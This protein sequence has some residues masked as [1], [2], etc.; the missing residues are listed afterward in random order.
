M[1]LPGDIP[2]MPEFLNDLLDRAESSTPS[3]KEKAEKDSR[4]TSEFLDDLTVS[5]ALRQ[6]DKAVTLVEEGRPEATSLGLP[7]NYEF[8]GETK[9]SAVPTL[10]PKL[11]PLKTSLT[12]SLLQSL[13][14]PNSRKSTVVH[15]ITLLL[16]LKAGAA[17]RSTFFTAR[18][19][20]LRKCV[21]MIP[22]EGHIG[23]YIA[24]LAIV[25]F[26]G[27]KHS[28]DWF[29][30]SFK[31]NE[32]ASCKF[33]FLKFV[34]AELILH[35]AFVEWAKQEVMNF[36]EM[37][38]KQVYGPDVDPQVVEEAIKITHLQ[39]KKVG[40]IVVHTSFFGVYCETAS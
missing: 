40:F 25:V 11:K 10:G 12:T 5:I 26:T 16:R 34:T 35:P 1:A 31:E 21:R 14:L 29:L 18:S 36:A 3:S 38:R 8:S 19:D 15:L 17:A 7:C 39:S 22:F 4:W 23:M 28:A 6:W 32:V 37:F 2:P 20:V 13:S 30:A 9:V 33:M 24:D 27:I